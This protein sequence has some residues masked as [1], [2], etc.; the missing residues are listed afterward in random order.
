MPKPRVIYNLMFNA[1]QLRRL[2]GTST[3]LTSYLRTDSCRRLIAGLTL[4]GVLDHEIMR[5]ERGPSGGT[6][7]HDMLLLDF[8]RWCK[9]DGYYVT[10]KR[11]FAAATTRTDG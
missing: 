5:V 11:L 7:L 3:P 6:Y 1:T 2:S 4:D 10:T 8:T 9:G